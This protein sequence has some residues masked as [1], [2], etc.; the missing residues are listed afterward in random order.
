MTTPSERAKQEAAAIVLAIAM[1]AKS[2]DP[3]E[4]VELIAIA[5]DAFAAEAVR[6]EREAIAAEFDIRAQVVDDLAAENV[7]DDILH[8]MLTDRSCE[9]R[10]HAAAIRARTPA[11]G[12]E[13]RRCCG[14]IGDEGHRDNCEY[15]DPRP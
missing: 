12:E 5:L 15:W 13:P 3:R 7:H 1:R 4:D 14:G 9:M 2:G 6:A 11:S 10:N 8:G